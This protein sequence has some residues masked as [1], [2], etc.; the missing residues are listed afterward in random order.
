MADF[1]V[2]PGNYPSLSEVKGMLIRR[3]DLGRKLPMSVAHLSWVLHTPVAHKMR[4]KARARG[5]WGLQAQ[6]EN[7]LVEGEEKRKERLIAG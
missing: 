4:V 2:E 7:I 3:H 5:R 1:R 6:G